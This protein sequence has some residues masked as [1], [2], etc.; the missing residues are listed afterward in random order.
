M[1]KYVVIF[2][3]LYDDNYIIL[4]NEKKL[5]KFLKYLFKLYP[6]CRVNIYKSIEMK[7][8]DFYES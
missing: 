3:R 8:S 2:G 1:F 4:E 6:G 5:K 7:V